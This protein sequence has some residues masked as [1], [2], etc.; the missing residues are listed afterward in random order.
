MGRRPAFVGLTI[1]GPVVFG[2][3]VQNI[4]SFADAGDS[5]RADVNQFL[6]QPFITMNLPNGW[7]IN[8]APSITANWNLENENR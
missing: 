2:A 3:L 5:N 6:L 8:S 1:R 4:W 7:Y